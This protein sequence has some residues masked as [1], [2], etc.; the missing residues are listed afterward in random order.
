MKF[1]SANRSWKEKR[2]YTEVLIGREKN[3][4]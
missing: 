2:N 4:H 1:G 3:L